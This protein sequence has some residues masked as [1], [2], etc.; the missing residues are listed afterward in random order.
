MDFK[1]MHLP[2]FRNCNECTMLING[3]CLQGKVAGCIWEL[4][5]TFAI[6]L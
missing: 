1:I 5:T 4:C 2:Q 6:F 3:L